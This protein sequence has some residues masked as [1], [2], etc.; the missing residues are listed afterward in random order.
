VPSS[1][2][3]SQALSADALAKLDRLNQR[4]AEITPK[5]TRRKTQREVI[6][7]KVVVEQRRRQHKRKKRRVVSGA[8]LEEGDGP[9]LKG[10][11]G[12]DRYDRYEKEVYRDDSRKSRKKICRWNFRSSMPGETQ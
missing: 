2:S 4:P 5:K 10:L 8:L 11:R 3:N 1:I 6:D 9:R 12:G 7:E